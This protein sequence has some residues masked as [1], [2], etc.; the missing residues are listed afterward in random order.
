MFNTTTPLGRARL[1]ISLIFAINGFLYANWTS[2]IPRLQEVYGIDN[3]QLGYVL[4][5]MSIG[6]LIAMPITGFVIVKT[7]SRFLTKL[8]LL[9]FIITCPLIALMPSY[10]ALLALG[11][12]VG[13]STGSLDIAM[14]AQAIIVEEGLKKPIMSSFHAIFSMG[15]LAGAGAASLFISL[16]A[17]VNVHLPIVSGISLLV[18]LWCIRQLLPES[19]LSTD[20]SAAEGGGFKLHK[21]VILL[22]LAAFCCMMGEGAMTDWT[23]VYMLRIAGSPEQWAPIGQAAFSGAMMIGR[24]GGDWAR[25]V[26]GSRA[27]IR[28]GGLL[29]LIGLSVALL[30]PYPISA[31][32]GFLLVGLGL[33]NIVPI[34]Y[35]VSGKIPGVPPGVGIS[36]VTT[37]GYSGFLFGPPI[38]G[39]I[40]D[41][42]N[43]ALAA[44]INPT[45]WW[46][47]GSWRG[48]Q[49]GLGFIWLLFLILVII[50]FFFLEVKDE[51]AEV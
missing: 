23:P 36:S 27:L 30:F 6:A 21:V 13:M 43:E 5:S 4:L 28:G 17:D 22:G 2:R 40:S 45:E 48:L 16:G 25:G 29:A 31:F 7:G 26:Y 49:F 42:H 9:F 12:M 3:S 46:L 44:G 15:M 50:A 18:A 11:I 33:S 1:A 39:F 19:T 47:D 10:W 37:I 38:I 41:W 8:M 51:P 14:N 34:A 32:L 35:S 24:F 20:S